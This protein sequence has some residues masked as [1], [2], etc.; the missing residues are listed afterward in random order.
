MTFQQEFDRVIEE[1]RESSP[2]DTWSTFLGRDWEG[3]RSASY[4]SHPDVDEEVW[5]SA[6]SYHGTESRPRPVRQTVTPVPTPNRAWV[7]TPVLNGGH[8]FPEDEG[9][10]DMDT[11]FMG[12]L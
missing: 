4:V 10:D 8:L 5:D 11:P 12:G 6:V 7:G 3:Y 2:S 9:I 1:T